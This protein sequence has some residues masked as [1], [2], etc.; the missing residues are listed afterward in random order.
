M[1]T[2]INRRLGFGT[3]SSSVVKENNTN[4]DHDWENVKENAKPL[5]RGRD[6]KKLNSFARGALSTRKAEDTRTRTKKDFEQQI[7]NAAE[8]PESDSLDPWIRYIKWTEEEYPAGGQQS[9]VLILLERCCRTFLQNN[10]FKNDERYIKIWL[11]YFDLLEEPLPLFRFLCANR[12]GERVSL[13]YIAWALVAEHAKNYGLADKV[14]TRGKNF[15][16]KPK[17]VLATRQ[18]QFQRRMARHWM[19][20]TSQ[21]DE[22]IP[23]SLTQASQDLTL[24]NENINSRG[25]RNGGASSSRGGLAN[26][27]SNTRNGRQRTSAAAQATRNKAKKSGGVSTMGNFNIFVEGSDENASS[28]AVGGQYGNDL[29]EGSPGSMNGG[30]RS[31]PTAVPWDHF[32]GKMEKK[33]ENDG[34]V[35]RWNDG[36]L[37]SQRKGS[38]LRSG[39]NRPRPSGFNICVDEDLQEKEDAAV[40]KNQKSAWQKAPSSSTSLRRRLEGPGRTVEEKEARDL[41]NDPL[42]N[43][44]NVGGAAEVDNTKKKLGPPR[45]PTMAAPPAPTTS[46]AKPTAVAPPIPAV[47]MVATGTQGT[48]GT[49][50]YSTKGNPGYHDSLLTE[51]GQIMSFEERRAMKYSFV[52]RQ[53]AIEKKQQ[54]V[55]LQQ[56]QQQQQHQQHKQANARSFRRGMGSAGAKKKHVSKISKARRS[57]MDVGAIQ[58]MYKQFE[59]Q[60]KEEYDSSDEEEDQSIPT[61]H[62]EEEEEEEVE[63]KEEKEEKNNSVAVAR[64]TLTFSNCSSRTTETKQT[65]AAV[66]WS[67][68]NKKNAST[69]A[70]NVM[71]GANATRKLTFNTSI[72]SVTHKEQPEDFSDSDDSS[73]D[74]FDTEAVAALQQNGHRGGHK[75]VIG[76]NNDDMTCNLQAAMDE[77]GDLFCSPGF[78]QMPQLSPGTASERPQ[79]SPGTASERSAGPTTGSSAFAIFQENEETKDENGENDDNGENKGPAPQ[80]PHARRTLSSVKT[81]SIL[82]EMRP[83]QYLSAPPVESEEDEED[84]E[85]SFPGPSA[86]AAVVAASTATTI[87]S[88]LDFG[89]YEDTIALP[90][91]SGA[92]MVYDDTV[93]LPTSNN[94]TADDAKIQQLLN[95]VEDDEETLNIEASFLKAAATMDETGASTVKQQQVVNK[96]KR[97]T[98]DMIS[99]LD[100]LDMTNESTD[101]H[102][103]DNDNNGGHTMD[104]LHGFSD[105][106]EEDENE[107]VVKKHDGRHHGRQE[108]RQQDRVAAKKTVPAAAKDQHLQKFSIFEDVFE[109]HEDLQKDRRA[110]IL[111]ARLD[112]ISEGEESNHG[113]SRSSGSSGKSLVEEEEEEHNHRRSSMDSLQG[114]GYLSSICCEED[115]DEGDDSRRWSNHSNDNTGFKR[116]MSSTPGVFDLPSTSAQENRSRSGFRGL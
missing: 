7:A 116:C 45:E 47:A 11:K 34:P 3:T 86:A 84:E 19:K 73:E 58:D 6:V 25:G 29:V 13:F 18:K 113:S 8:D 88:S 109:E 87:A 20:Q 5:K 110:T 33:K 72:Q 36:G 111:G 80:M 17:K 35:T 30:N 64:K 85:V 31:D 74:E 32:A 16:A 23:N 42:K 53:A 40:K 68:I 46:F 83:D 37:E 89:V 106:E 107:A 55:V 61:I 56:Q 104:L 112:G 10:G 63:Q 76:L 4:G 77:L 93:A 115:E 41:F 1:S 57:T 48:K 67:P 90:S 54:Q 12:I 26:G 49:T 22:P 51:Q 71:A 2:P 14:F 95:Q 39:R 96:N 92:F 98:L 94:L 91:S 75:N 50:S 66:N 24:F 43:I 44:R 62:E 103:N 108:F 70:S 97:S 60:S 15:I 105:T 59:Q 65:M 21:D 99:G 114:V 27:L 102:N 100:S 78:K 28:L 69:P 81:S 52:A 82:S 38:R 9:N 79:L 101:N